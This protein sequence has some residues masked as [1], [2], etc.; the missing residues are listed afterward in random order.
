MIFVMYILPQIFL[1][2]NAVAAHIAL[3]E[4]VIQENQCGMLSICRIQKTGRHH[5]WIVVTTEGG[6]D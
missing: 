2:K 1:K 4:E 3:G 5:Q 6:G